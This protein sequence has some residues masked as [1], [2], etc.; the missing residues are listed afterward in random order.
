MSCFTKL[1]PC[2]LFNV[3]IKQES[4]NIMDHVLKLG[5]RR[6]GPTT[7]HWWEDEALHDIKK[8]KDEISN[9]L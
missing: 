2:K 8:T 1:N 4:M 5:I 9:N 7:L 6:Y 3:R